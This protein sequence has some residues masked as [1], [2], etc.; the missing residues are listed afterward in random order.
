M[1]L[2]SCCSAHWQSRSLSPLG[3][4]QASFCKSC[5][6]C[7]S[8]SLLRLLL[9]LIL[10]HPL[11]L[12]PRLVDIELRRAAHEEGAPGD[13]RALAEG[14][15]AAVPH[16]GVQSEVQAAPAQG[17][18]YTGCRARR[19][20]LKRRGNGALEVA[21]GVHLGHASGRESP[22]HARGH[23]AVVALGV[24]AAPGQC[25]RGAALAPVERQAAVQAEIHCGA[26]L[27]VTAGGSKQGQ[28][29]SHLACSR[30]LKK[31]SEEGRER[32]HLDKQ[33]KN[34]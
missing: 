23:G 1:A 24:V 16:S 22:V 10:Q 8:C 6:P 3:C 32:N 2:E 17:G 27:G 15:V 20:K 18:A 12:L 28:Q 30:C 31:E 29:E 4:R 7:C 33:K 5:D 14:D 19:G 13:R 21:L 34:T 26:C 9:L 25:R 11:Q